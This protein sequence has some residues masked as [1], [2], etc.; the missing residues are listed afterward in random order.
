ML[1]TIQA[2][3]PN[4][5]PNFNLIIAFSLFYS[6]IISNHCESSSV[7]EILPKIFFCTNRNSHQVKN[8]HFTLIS[9]CEMS[10]FVRLAVCFAK[11]HTSS[12]SWGPEKTEEPSQ[13]QPAFNHTKC[14]IQNVLIGNSQ[15]TFRPKSITAIVWKA[16]L[17]DLSSNGKRHIQSSRC[18][19]HRVDPT[20]SQGHRSL[21]VPMSKQISFH[22]NFDEKHNN[23][24]TQISEWES[25]DRSER[26]AE[27]KRR[28]RKARNDSQLKRARRNHQIVLC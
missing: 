8:V 5:N 11:L 25:L 6:G 4:L 18:S 24:S 7:N 9:L 12:H 21:C 19:R 16:I 28:K 2:F 17:C 3:W 26:I 1:Q 22:P 15:L 20:S 23:Y 14:A 27:G 13:P 10:V